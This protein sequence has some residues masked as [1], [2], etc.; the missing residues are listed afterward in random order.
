MLMTDCCAVSSLRHA[1]NTTRRQHGLS[2]DWTVSYPL[3]ATCKPAP[4]VAGD[5]RL[6]SDAVWF[7]PSLPLSP[8]VPRAFS[9]ATANQTIS[10]GAVNINPQATTLAN[11]CTLN[12]INNLH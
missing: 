2:L 3:L 1:W 7:T 10:R 9:N 12:Y 4:M 5:D 11:I 6:K 8:G